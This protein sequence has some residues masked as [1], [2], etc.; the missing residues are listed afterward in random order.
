MAFSFNGSSNYIRLGSAGITAYP[1]TL[2]AWF[3][4]TNTNTNGVV[5]NL[6][7]GARGD[8][9]FRLAC[10]N[11][12]AP[13][14]DVNAPSGGYGSVYAVTSY[15]AGTWHHI[16]GVFASTTSRTVYLDGGGSAT[17]TTT[18]G[19]P[20][21]CNRTTAGVLDRATPADYFGGDIAECAVWSAAL[22]EA[23]VISLAKGTG[24]PSVR[25]QSLV[26]YMPLIRELIEIRTGAVPTNNS[27]TVSSHCRVYR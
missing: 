9:W 22:T 8:T 16:C 26:S 1:V 19:T 13:F 11:A 12:A 10:T 4:K 14:I 5:L 15:T 25:P 21:T 18:S 27:A 24:A 7:D 23:E 3:K 20:S 2:S 6:V 17:Q